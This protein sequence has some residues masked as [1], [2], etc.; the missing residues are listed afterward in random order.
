VA[1]RYKEAQSRIST[2]LGTKVDRYC[3]GVTRGACI[4]LL[5]VFLVKE[6]REG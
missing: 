5:S 3:S 4:K 2:M 6:A 1:S